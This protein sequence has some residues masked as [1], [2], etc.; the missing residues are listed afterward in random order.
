LEAERPG[1]KEDMGGF[2]I[3][4]VKE[5]GPFMELVRAKYQLINEEVK[6]KKSEERPIAV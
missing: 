6:G 3:Q 1:E 4:S 2:S 5:L